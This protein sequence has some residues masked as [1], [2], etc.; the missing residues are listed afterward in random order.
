[1]YLY[2][3]ELKGLNGIYQ[4]FKYVFMEILGF[5]PPAKGTA[6]TALLNWENQL[7]AL[8]EGDMP[9]NLNINYV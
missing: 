6:N 4:I 3:G 9:Y 8:H 1:M 5:L 2:F 7:Y